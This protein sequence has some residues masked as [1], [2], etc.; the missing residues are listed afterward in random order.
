MAGSSLAMLT[1]YEMQKKS[2][3][4]SLAFS[5]L[6]NPNSLKWLSTNTVN[7]IFDMKMILNWVIVAILICS[8][9]V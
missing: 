3:C 7:I 4:I 6:C 8:P 1:H 9:V 2:F 5:Q